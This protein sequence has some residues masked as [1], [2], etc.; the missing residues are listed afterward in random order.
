MRKLRNATAIITLSLALAA[1]DNLL[2]GEEATE[3]DAASQ[4]AGVGAGGVGAG[5]AGNGAMAMG[6]NSSPFA[7][8]GE[9]DDPRFIGAGMASA[10]NTD[11]IGKDAADCQSLLDAGRVQPNPL[12]DT[13]ANDAAINYGD[14]SGSYP[15]DGECDDIR[16]TGEYA[17]AMVYIV[18]EIGHDATDCRN[19]VQSG[20]ARWQGNTATPEYGMTLEELQARGQ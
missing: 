14:D 10:L 8:D 2:G 4:A 6:D 17:S 11:W 16:F 3:G 9:C 18:D 19:A 12:F 20:Q 13:P 5:P 7:N 1:C 15:N